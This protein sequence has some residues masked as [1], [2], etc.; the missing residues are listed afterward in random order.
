MGSVT[1]WA[2]A[3]EIAH[4]IGAVHDGSGSAVSCSINAMNIMTPNLRT[5]TVNQYN[6]AYRFSDCSIR[7]IKKLLTGETDGY[8]RICLT[9]KACVLYNKQEI[10]T[11]DL[12]VDV[13]F[14]A[15]QNNESISDQCKSRYSLSH[16]DCVS[17]LTKILN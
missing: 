5:W 16:G 4:L 2:V 11:L 6:S 13:N 17:L 12:N 15:R 7:D 8:P 14:R 3:H 9:N 10:G 1:W